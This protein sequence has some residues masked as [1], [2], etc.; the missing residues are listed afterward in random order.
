L[1]YGTQVLGYGTTQL[2]VSDGVNS[3][4]VLRSGDRIPGAPGRAHEGE[5]AISEIL[6]GQHP[7]QV[8]AFGR[9]AFAAEFLLNPSNPQDPNNQDP[10]NVI[11][12]LVIGIPR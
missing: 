9:L 7:A 8:D 12:A 1:I 5:L 11:T 6:F 4:I 10:S 2:F 3:Q